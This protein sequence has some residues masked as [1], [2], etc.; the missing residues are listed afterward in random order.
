MT[1]NTKC[2]INFLLAG[3]LAVSAY[4]QPGRLGSEGCGSRDG[5][6]FYATYFAEPAL[7]P[8][9]QI[10]IQGHDDVIHEDAQNG[11]PTVFH[12]LFLDPESKSYIGYDV[13]VE[14]ADRPGLAR[15]RF[16]PVSLRADQL[17]KQY[18]AADYRLLPAPE[19]PAETFPS[20]QT[21]AVEVLKN[22]TTGQKVVDYIEVSF[23]PI[24][25]PSSAAPRDFQAA[26][27]ILHI[28]GP[29]LLVNGVEVPAGLVADQMVARKLVWLSVPGRGR[30]LLSLAPYPGYPFQ[31]AGA[32]TAYGLSFAWSG[33]RYEWRS[34]ELITESSGNWNLYVLQAPPD[35][36]AKGFSFGA[37]NSVEEFLSRS[38][39]LH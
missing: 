6:K 33:D 35:G 30:F 5:W 29:S 1:N 25:L 12:R 13:E 14:P 28:T 2:L 31:K 22:P 19:F 4:G 18:H 34:R 10:S 20:G 3:G 27:V 38:Q 39:H 32:T 36:S 9:Q 24:H 23:E 17:P 37:V 21:I 7:A 16:K 26:D 15:L 11:R 8:G